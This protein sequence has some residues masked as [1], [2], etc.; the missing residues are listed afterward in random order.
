MFKL[1]LVVNGETI[2]AEGSTI[3]SAIKKLKRPKKIVKTR[4]LITITHKSGKSHER[5]L[6]VPRV[7]ALYN[8]TSDVYREIAAKNFELF[9]K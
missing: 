1:K 6:T 9:L 2:R 5:S 8:K 4:G 7:N 3:L